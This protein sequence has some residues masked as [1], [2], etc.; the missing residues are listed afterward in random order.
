MNFS[1]L[2]KIHKSLDF[3]SNKLKMTLISF[4]KK[5]RLPIGKVPCNNSTLF[6]CKESDILGKCMFRYEC[7]ALGNTIESLP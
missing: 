6:H 2:S 3:Q 5:L 1:K 4:K 7:F